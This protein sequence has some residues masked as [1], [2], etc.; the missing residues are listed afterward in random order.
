MFFL[1]VCLSTSCVLG[2]EEEEGVGFPG[3]GGNDQPEVIPCESGTQTWLFRESS[4]CS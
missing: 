2:P 3:A 1:H 4:R